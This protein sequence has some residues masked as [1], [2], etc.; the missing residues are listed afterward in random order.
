MWR[1]WFKTEIIDI[2]YNDECMVYKLIKTIDTMFLLTV[3]FVFPFL[4]LARFSPGSISKKKNYIKCETVTNPLKMCYGLFG[5]RGP[6]FKNH[7]A[8]F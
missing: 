6:Q 5:V 8:R 7:C 4:L 1:S 2:L 3:L